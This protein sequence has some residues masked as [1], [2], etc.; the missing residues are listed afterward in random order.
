MTIAVADQ[1][2]EAGLHAMNVSALIDHILT[3]FHAV[4]RAELPELI[5]LARKV[6]RVH[7]DVPEAPRGLADALVLLEI[8][9]EQHMLKEELVLFPAMR[10]GQ[11]PGVAEATGQMR[12]DHDFQEQAIAIISEIT[13]GFALPAGACGSWQRL[14]AGTAK[15]CGD[16]ARH[17]LVEN[18]VLFPRFELAR[19]A[20]CICAHR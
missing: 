10:E 18:D 5:A 20:A 3:K 12:H 15:L 8:D 14:Y 2:P 17:M 1:K 16:L 19:P 7:A 9:L 6:E 11:N 13:R 4:H